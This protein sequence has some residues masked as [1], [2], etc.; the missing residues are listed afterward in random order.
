TLLVLQGPA[1]LAFARAFRPASLVAIALLLLSALLALAIQALQVGGDAPFASLGPLLFGTRYG[2]IWLARVALVLALG[3][4]VLVA[5]SRQ[6][7]AALGTAL[8]AALL[9]TNS[10]NSHGAASEQLPGLAIAA[11]WLHQVAVATW[12]GELFAL[13][14]LLWRLDWAPPGTGRARA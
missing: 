10:L 2:T 8:G 12:V 1:A 6:G 5:P 13:A 7:V 9:L 4:L 11:D 3:A 14:A